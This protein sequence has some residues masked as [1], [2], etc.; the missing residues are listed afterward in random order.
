[1]EK[2]EATMD[3][4]AA[5]GGAVVKAE[6]DAT[7]R[8]RTVAEENII[9]PIC[10]KVGWTETMNSIVGRR[11]SFFRSSY[12]RRRQQFL[13]PWSETMTLVARHVLL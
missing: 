6:A 12:V 8:A 7:T 9:L 2:G 10:R 4:R 5:M 13:P 11:E 1:M 3:D